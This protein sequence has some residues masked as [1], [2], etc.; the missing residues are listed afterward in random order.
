MARS[1]RSTR[2]STPEDREAR[3]AAEREKV[4]AAVKALQTSDG[5]L[6]WAKVRKAF[7]RYSP[8]NQLLIAQQMP[9][10][11]RVAGFKAWLALGYCV[12]RGEQSIRIWGPMPPS[13]KAIEQWR[14]DGADPSDKPRTR[15]R[16]LPVFDVS[17]VDPLPPPAVA[18]PLEA[19]QVMVDLDGDDLAW[20]W[21]LLVAFGAREL[22]TPV[23]LE[24]LPPAG[25]YGY[26][27]RKRGRQTRIAV[28]CHLS[29]N[30]R[31]RVGVHELSHALVDAD[32]RVAAEGS[33]PG[34]LS[35]ADEELVVE[36][37]ACLVCATLGLDV[38]AASIPYLADWASQSKVETIEAQAKTIDALARRLEDA[39]IDADGQPL[40]PESL[41]VDC[42][43]VLDDDHV[44]RCAAGAATDVRAAV[45]A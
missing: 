24:D 43:G 10:A 11:T 13:K 19:P 20:T 12:R 17:Q 6:A 1:R 28:A 32:R 8:I 33:E 34:Q 2:R 36:T 31:A 39:L 30:G 35:Y 14:K 38:S 27:Q 16:M 21:P 29:P 4:V 26:Y 9:D 7:R 3:L 45:A 15:F 22:A 41:C 37:V 18:T 25:P 42:G 23:E 40:D 44:A 5:W